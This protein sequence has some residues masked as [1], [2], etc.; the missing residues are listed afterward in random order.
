[1]P[2]GSVVYLITKGHEL[3]LASQRKDIEP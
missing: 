2:R 1:V 3:Y